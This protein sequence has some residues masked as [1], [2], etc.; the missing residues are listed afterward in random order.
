MIGKSRSLGLEESFFDSFSRYFRSQPVL[1]G[2]W[3]EEVKIFLCRRWRV[4]SEWK[5]P[6]QELVMA[7][8]PGIVQGRS[9]DLVD[10]LFSAIEWD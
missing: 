10:S 6:E 3:D 5:L 8:A 7:G 2:G 4:T 1:D 9:Y